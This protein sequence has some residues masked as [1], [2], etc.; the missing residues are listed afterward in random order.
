MKILHNLGWT[1]YHNPTHSD[2]LLLQWYFKLG[3]NGFSTVQCIVC[4]IWMGKMV[5]NMGGN[6]FR[7]SKCAAFQ[8]W[9]QERNPKSGKSK[10]KDKLI[11]GS[12]NKNCLEPSRIIFSDQYE[13]RIT[14]EVFGNRV[15]KVT[16]QF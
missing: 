7:I 11:E 6:N 1:P 3:H 16:S 9:K 10:S 2:K 8:Y 5:E 15:S 13:S 14:G 4:Q 12:L